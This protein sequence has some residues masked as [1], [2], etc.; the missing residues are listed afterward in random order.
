VGKLAPIGRLFSWLVG[1]AGGLGLGDSSTAR[2]LRRRARLTLMAVAI[3][4]IGL[5]L[6]LLTEE[7]GSGTGLLTGLVAAGGFTIHVILDPA[8]LGFWHH[9]RLKFIGLGVQAAAILVQ[10]F[11]LPAWTLPLAAILL[12]AL[13]HQK[14]VHTLVAGELANAESLRIK[15]LGLQ[16]EA[17]QKLLGDDKGRRAG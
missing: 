7:P 13:R 5:A 15:V 6:A 16:A 12:I 4:A 2:L 17:Q 10:T 11:W 14:A 1:L 3:V 8:R 9:R